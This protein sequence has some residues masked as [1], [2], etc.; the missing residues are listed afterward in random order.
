MPRSIAS[1]SMAP[2]EVGIDL[3]KLAATREPSRLAEN[4][5]VASDRDQNGTYDKRIIG[6]NS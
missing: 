4:G 2:P 1:P 5:A 3:W 6:T